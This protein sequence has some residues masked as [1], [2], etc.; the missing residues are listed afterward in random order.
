MA[1]GI[2]RVPVGMSDVV[3]KSMR[4]GRLYFKEKIFFSRPVRV[5][6]LSATREGR[7]NIDGSLLCFAGWDLFFFYFFLR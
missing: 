6:V 1:K 5:S 3:G 2:T 4:G 7:W